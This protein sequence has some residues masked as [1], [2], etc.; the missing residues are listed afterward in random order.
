MSQLLE[1]IAR[2]MSELFDISAARD[3]ANTHACADIKVDDKVLVKDAPA[4]LLDFDDDGIPGVEVPDDDAPPTD[5]AAL[6]EGPPPGALRLPPPRV[7]GLFDLL[8][9]GG[10]PLEGG[11]VSAPPALVRAY[12]SLG[13]KVLGPPAWDPDFNT[14]DLP[15]MM[16]L[17]Q[18]PPRVRRHFLRA[19]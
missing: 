19:P 5:R 7:G 3:W 6:L 17:D 11:G 2:E 4:P 12:L 8:A 16:R 14:A 9:G 10:V 1:E 13:A 15:L 18:L